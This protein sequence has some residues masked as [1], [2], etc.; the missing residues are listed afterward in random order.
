MFAY[1]KP[2][3]TLRICFRTIDDTISWHNKTSCKQNIPYLSS[4]I[5]NKNNILPCKCTSGSH[6]LESYG[7]QYQPTYE[8]IPPATTMPS[9][10]LLHC[11]TTPTPE[12]STVNPAGPCNILI[13]NQSIYRCHRIAQD[14]STT[15][16]LI[17]FYS[18]SHII[19]MPTINSKKDQRHSRG[20]C[21]ALTRIIAFHYSIPSILRTINTRHYTDIISKNISIFLHCQ[22]FGDYFLV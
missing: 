22:F 21:S 17:S 3:N 5:A 20:Y 19:V 1:I 9:T 13:N 18:N 15:A 7:L 6:F 14:N 16:S 12:L 8:C 4:D 10:K 11:Q 2:S